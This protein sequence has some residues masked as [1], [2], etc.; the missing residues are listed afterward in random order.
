[1]NTSEPLKGRTPRIKPDP[2]LSLLM[3][4][5]NEER[6]LADCLRS[7]QGVVDEMII[8]DTGSSDRTVEIARSF[9]AAVFTYP[10]DGSFSNARNEALSHCTCNYVLYLDADERLESKDRDR[11][12]ALMHRPSSDAYEINVVSKRSEAGRIIRTSSDQ[13]RLFRRDPRYRFRYRIHESILPSIHEAGGEVTKEAITVHHVGYDASAT[14][15]EQKKRRNYEQLMLDVRDYPNDLFVRKKY[16]Q[17]LLMMNKAAE[18][19]EE[20]RVTMEKIGR[21]ACGFIAPP[22]RAAFCNLYAD[23][24]MRS[25]DYAGAK[26]WALES[27]KALKEQNSAHYFLTIVCDQLGEYEEAMEHLNSIC[28]MK[29]GR[30]PVAEDEITPAPQDIC[31]KRASLYRA[32]KKPIEER[33]ELNAALRIDPSMTA[34]LFDLAALMARE[35]NFIQ[36]LSM[37]TKATQTDPANGSV[38]HLRAKILYQMQRKEEALRDAARAFQLGDHSDGLLGFWIQ[39]AK[40]LK[41]EAHSMPALAMMSERYPASGEIVLAYIQQLIHHNDIA[42][43]SAVVRTSLPAVKDPMLRQTLSAIQEKLG[44]AALVQMQK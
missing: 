19:A 17:T 3:I 32:L 13:A 4:V 40:E 35:N 8:V 27:L 2:L 14:V 37:I 15:M 23:A 18:A 43:S 26:H 39:A 38:F 6:V 5:R 11:L 7:V 34:A 30:P 12:R 10:W 28:S 24:L 16:I 25:N 9:G 22:R 33:R 20:C 42:R 21:G 36:A 31:Y 29:D 1:M 44:Q 41:K